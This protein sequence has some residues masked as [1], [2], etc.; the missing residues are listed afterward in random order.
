MP[1]H[2][3]RGE[4]LAMSWS[5]PPLNRRAMLAQSAQ[6]LGAAAL[7]SASSLPHLAA[8]EASRQEAIWDAHVHLGGTGSVEERVDRL[9]MYA[10]RMSIERLVVFMGTRFVQDPSPEEL[11][12]QND[13]VLR[14]IA[15]APSRLLGMV[16]LNPRHVS[17][18]LEELDRCVADGPMVG[19]KLWV[20]IRC[21]EPELDPIVRRAVELKV[22]LFQHA[23]D[24]VREDLNLPG[25]STTEDMAIL[26]A[27]HPDA[28][29]VCLHTGAD[30]ERGIRRIRAC[31]NVCA[32]VSGSDPT[33]GMVE[34]AVREL[35]AQRVVFG[36]DAPGRS[37]ASQLA[38]VY[39]ADLPAEARQLVLGGNLRRL[40]HQALR[41]KGN[42]P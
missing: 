40:L 34:M 13:D 23:F 17:A 35:G 8:H 2:H 20:A 6:A 24:R 31:P 5:D 38:K 39:S 3:F 4:A 9:L 22:P 36:S 7:V 11:R 25:E 32:E 1:V 37:Y 12:R 41:R 16:Y 30:W 26:A 28:S 19:I 14:A 18:S 27:R 15:H 21:R 33:A 42:Q 10:N 29:F